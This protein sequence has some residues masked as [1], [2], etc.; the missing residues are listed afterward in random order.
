ML[1][2]GGPL[3]IVL[4]FQHPEFSKYSKGMDSDRSEKDSFKDQG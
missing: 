4:Q 3:L 1:L 2:P